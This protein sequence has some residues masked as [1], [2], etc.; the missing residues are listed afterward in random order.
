MTIYDLM[1]AFVIGLLGLF[2]WENAGF[3]DRAIALAKQHCEHLEV[4]L[5]D[6][7]IAL[8]KVKFKKDQRGNLAISRLYEFEFTSTGDQR[9]KGELTL[10]GKRLMH[11]ELEPHRV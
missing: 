7:T 2:I 11:V 9:Y 4:Q 1:I 6:D 5:L 8:L 3:R 10:H